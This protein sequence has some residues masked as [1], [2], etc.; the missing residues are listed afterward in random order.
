MVEFAHEPVLGGSVGEVRVDELLMSVTGRVPRVGG[1]QE[2]GF[3]Q[4]VLWGRRGRFRPRRWLAAHV[5]WLKI[6]MTTPSRI[7]ANTEPPTIIAPV[8]RIPE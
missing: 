3:D 4:A 8:D 1:G 5:N 6:G 2:L 7:A